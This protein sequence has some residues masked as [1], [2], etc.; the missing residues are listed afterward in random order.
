MPLYFWMPLLRMPLCELI[1]VFIYALFMC[2]W[3]CQVHTCIVVLWS[4]NKER[5]LAFLLV[6]KYHSLFADGRVIESL[7]KKKAPLLM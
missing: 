6:L 4:P 1:D 3:T 7:K 2:A 5:Y